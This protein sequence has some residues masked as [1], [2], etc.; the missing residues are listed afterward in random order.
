MGKLKSFA[1]GLGLFL[2]VLAGVGIWLASP[3]FVLLA[4][5][6]GFAAWMIATR[7]GQQSASVTQIG[8]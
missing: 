2:V 4:L 8:L 1:R 5:V 7:R 3:W 6:L